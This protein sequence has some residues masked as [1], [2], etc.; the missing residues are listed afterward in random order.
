MQEKV[1][2]TVPKFDQV[3]LVQRGMDAVAENINNL[4]MFGHLGPECLIEAQYH[5]ILG[6]ITVIN[7]MTD[8]KVNLE[9]AIAEAAIA[10]RR[11]LRK[12]QEL[13]RDLL[14]NAVDN[15]QTKEN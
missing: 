6:A 7:Y 3:N 5:H 14:R 11:S 12:R 4:R 13:Q 10:K 8:G 15:T 1:I 9:D 2:F